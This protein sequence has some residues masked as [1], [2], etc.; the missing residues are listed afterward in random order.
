MA[1]TREMP[2]RL[3]TDA[4][5]PLYLLMAYAKARREDMTPEEKRNIR[6]LAALLKG[7]RK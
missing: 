3:I 2:G 1:Y 7:Q 4:G 6:R 5:R